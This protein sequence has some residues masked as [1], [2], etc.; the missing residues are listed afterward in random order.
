ML[1]PP[2]NMRKTIFTAAGDA[3]KVRF[4]EVGGTAEVEVA[5]FSTQGADMLS[6]AWPAGLVAGKSYRVTVERTDVNGV[7]RI[8]AA[9]TVTVKAGEP[10]PPEPIRYTSSDL[11]R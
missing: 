10:T 6:F 7:T 4:A 3:D 1:R 2:R 5:D 11:S 9:K 8:S